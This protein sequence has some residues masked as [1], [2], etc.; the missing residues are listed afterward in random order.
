MIDTQTTIEKQ[1]VHGLPINGTH[2][3]QAAIDAL[4]GGSFLA[5]YWYARPGSNKLGSQVDR[6]IELVG[7]DETFWLDNGAFTAFKNGISIADDEA[8]LDGFYAWAEDIT[9]RC[10]QALVIIPDVI[11]GSTAQNDDMIREALGSSIGH[12]RMVP[13]WHLHEDLDWLTSLAKDFN[14]VAIGSSGDF[15]KVNSP[16]WKAR[17]DEMFTHL[18]ALYADPDFAAAY[19]QPKIHMLRGIAVMDA[20]RFDSADSVNIAVNHGRQAKQGEDL[21]AFRTRVETKA[22]QGEGYGDSRIG[23]AREITEENDNNILSFGGGVDST[24]LLAIELNRDIAA[25]RLGIS[26]EELN[27]KFPPVDAVVFS[28]PGAEFPGTYDNVEYARGRCEAQGIRFEV[29]AKEENIVE[30]MTRLGNIPLM[31][32]CGHVCSLKFKAEVLHKWAAA[33][34]TGTITWA[35]GI[36]ANETNRSF[37][38]KP[39]G[40]HQ[41]SHPLVDLGLTRADCE[42]IIEALGWGI[43]VRKSSCWFCPF[44]KEHELRDLH[45]NHPDLW[46][47]AEAIEDN[48]KAMS[49]IKHQRWLDAVDAGETDPE[50]RAPTGQWKKDSHAGGARLFSGTQIKGKRLS[51]R[52][53][54]ERFATIEEH[55][56]NNQ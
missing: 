29:V 28:D 1:V 38:S 21:D 44:Q 16:E 55:T 5:S 2:N 15:W 39:G 11:D 20:H 32:G 10:P 50:K 52:E 36:E 7:A 40:R 3:G 49:K 19:V 35:I 42:D 9:D 12:E 25:A 33:E 51:V 54:A 18:D 48:F 53:W 30:W 31:P 27:I 22:K 26:L 23:S 37:T 13:V 17:I 47:Q 4:A 45:D 24:A 14:H 46:A 56:V 41:C 43:Q 8:Y 34:F 6:A